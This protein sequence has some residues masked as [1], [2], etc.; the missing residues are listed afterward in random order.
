MSEMDQL[1]KDLEKFDTKVLSQWGYTSDHIE[2]FGINDPKLYVVPDSEEIAV[3]KAVDFIKD[4][5]ASVVI[6]GPLGSGKTTFMEIITN[7]LNK[8]P[9]VR[10]IKIEGVSSA[11]AFIDDI[12]NADYKDGVSFGEYWHQNFKVRLLRHGTVAK[13]LS[14]LLLAMRKSAE[15]ENLRYILLIDEFRQL[16]RI[17]EES[18]TRIIDT[19]LKMVNEKT[20]NGRRYLNLILAVITRV[21]ESAY[22]TVE[23]LSTVGESLGHGAK[24]AIRRRFVEVYDIQKLDE[25][26]A[27]RIMLYRLSHLKKSKGIIKNRPTIY[28]LKKEDVKKAI[29]PFDVSGLKAIYRFSGGNPGSMLEL[30]IKLLYDSLRGTETLTKEGWSLDDVVSQYIINEEYVLKFASREIQKA[31]S[32]FTKFQTD[33][34]NFVATPR[35]LDEIQDWLTA[36]AKS[37]DDVINDFDLFEKRGLIHS[38]ERGRIQATDL[39]LRGSQY[40]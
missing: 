21:G 5:T 3:K 1:L 32:E 23:I 22:Q 34:L 33:L 16:E 9:R 39:W 28:Q 40:V 19:L 8:L 15:Q 13:R 6:S 2:L 14:R 30:L 35:M 36:Q 18:R 17:R 20:S 25:E 11:D 7:S 12:I 10:T 24:S 31:K 26:S 29:S 37:W 4:S 38:P 27:L